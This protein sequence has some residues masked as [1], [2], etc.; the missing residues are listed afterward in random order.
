MVPYESAKV[1]DIKREVI[2]GLNANH[3]EVCK[4]SSVEDEGYRAVSGAIIDYI[5]EATSGAYMKPF[6]VYVTLV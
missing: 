3:H 5:L 4:F 1:G 2:R 6:L